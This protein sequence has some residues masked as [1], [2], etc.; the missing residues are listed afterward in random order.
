MNRSSFQ[1]INLLLKSVARVQ[2]FQSTWIWG[3]KQTRFS[4]LPLNKIQIQSASGGGTRKEF[5]SVRPT[6][7]KQWL[8]FQSLSPKC[9]E[10]TPKFIKEK[11]GT[12]VGGNVQVGSEG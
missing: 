5:I 7:G 2:R 8:T 4:H 1:I 9:W 11:C 12:K 3:P 6:P 10:K